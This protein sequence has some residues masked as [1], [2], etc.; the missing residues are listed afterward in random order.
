MAATP[1]SGFGL[2]RGGTRPDSTL[3]YQSP[4]V[5]EERNKVVGYWQARLQ[6]QL[7]FTDVHRC[8]RRCV[9][10]GE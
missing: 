7:Q 8:P 6:F 1:R 4:T 5:Y 2:M 10:S 9:P 3:G